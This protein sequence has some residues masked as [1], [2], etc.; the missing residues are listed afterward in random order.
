MS[1]CTEKNR[2][3]DLSERYHSDGMIKSELQ[4]HHVITSYLVKLK[5]TISFPKFLKVI[6]SEKNNLEINFYLKTMFKISQDT[7]EESHFFFNLC[8]N[9]IG[10]TMR[11]ED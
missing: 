8:I 6:I 7:N 2:Y 1:F 9:L 10:W 3:F 4:K 5:K 11:T